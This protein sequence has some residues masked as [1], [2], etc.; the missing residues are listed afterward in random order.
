MCNLPAEDDKMI[1]ATVSDAVQQ[2]GYVVDRLRDGRLSRSMASSM[3]CTAWMNVPPGGNQSFGKRA[4]IDPVPVVGM[5]LAG[6][7]DLL[8]PAG[9][10]RAPCRQPAARPAAR[11][12]IRRFRR[13][14]H[15]HR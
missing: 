6:R 9:R 3:T 7:Q 4:A 12:A 8:D 11:P 13:G 1:V 5:G 15:R 2:D 14:R 10:G